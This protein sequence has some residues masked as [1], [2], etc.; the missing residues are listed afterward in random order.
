MRGLWHDVGLMR[1]K[2]KEYFSVA[3]VI[4]TTNL[5]FEIGVMMVNINKFPSRHALNLEPP[6][7]EPAAGREIPESNC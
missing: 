6:V 3:E 5:S 2:K 7:I 1:A 4:L